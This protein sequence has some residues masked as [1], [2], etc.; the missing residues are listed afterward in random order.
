MSAQFIIVNNEDEMRFESRVGDSYAFVEY[1]WYKGDIAFTHTFVPTVARGTG[2]SSALAKYALD[3]AKERNLKI[4]IYCPFIAKY[5]KEH[6]E[7]RDLI[8]KKY[9]S[10]T[11]N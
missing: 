3:Y 2:L 5:I 10:G 9:Q 4:M 8:D 11:K 7:Y 1:R 6:P